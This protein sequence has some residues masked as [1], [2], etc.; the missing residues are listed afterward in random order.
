[1]VNFNLGSVSEIVY[2]MIADVPSNVS[3]AVLLNIIDQ[4]RVFMENYT[5][6]SIGSTA[7]T[8]K[9]QPALIDLSC[10]ELSKTIGFNGG[11]VSST[12]LGDL[13]VNKN[14]S[15]NETMTQQYKDS[16]MDKLKILGR[17]VA[18]KR[19]WGV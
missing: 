2:N 18:F 10:A 7:I 11:V 15:S 19:V 13:S 17:K 9:F 16:G 3:G 12:S 14:T 4:Q 6:Q 1:M 8:E 5:G